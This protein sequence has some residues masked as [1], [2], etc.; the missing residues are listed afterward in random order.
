MYKFLSIIYSKALDIY[1]HF[2]SLSQEL[3][4]QLQAEL[5]H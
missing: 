3:A 1:E 4:M 5:K 2:L